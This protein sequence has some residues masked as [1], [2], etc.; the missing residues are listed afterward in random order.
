MSHINDLSRDLTRLLER[1]HKAER[2][3]SDYAHLASRASDY[4]DH[5]IDTDLAGMTDDERGEH[6]RLYFQA[7]ALQH[8]ASLLK[9]ESIDRQIAAVAKLIGNEA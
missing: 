7:H 1:R 2:L 4:R 3:A 8:Q 6:Q 5:H 9:L